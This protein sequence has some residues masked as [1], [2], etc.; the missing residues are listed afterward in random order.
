[1]SQRPFVLIHSPLVGALTWQPVAQILRTHGYEVFSPALQDASDSTFRFWQQEVDSIKLTIRDA[2][3]VGHSGAGALLPAVGEKLNAY[4]Y[5]FVDA[6]LL[7]ESA[8]RLELMHTEDIDFA[9]EFKS[10]LEAGGQFPNWTDEQLQDIIPDAALRRDLLAD[11][12]PRG[13]RFF[14]ER[15]DAPTGWE[16]KPCAYLQ[17]SAFYSLYADQAEQLGW[18]VV[19]RKAH[20]FEM[21]TQPQAIAALLME[22]GARL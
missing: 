7:L 12:R 20:H 21:M 1:M 6:V 4:G 14:T 8:S 22:L 18:P 11:L 16:T 19:R 9:R 2:V 17:L 15:I 13:L 10:Y 3:L 5:L